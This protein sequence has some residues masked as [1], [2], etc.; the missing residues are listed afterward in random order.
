MGIRPATP[1][2]LVVIAATILLILVSVS[3][4]LLKSIYFLK[5]TIDASIDGTD[6]SGTV[7]LGAWGYCVGSTCSTPKLGYSLDVAEL[8]G[9]S[10]A[11]TGISTS[12]LKWI[13][14][15]MVLHPIA[16]AFGVVSVIFGLL[17]HIRGFAGTA[18]TTCFASFA[19]T[20]AS[21]AFIFDIVVFVIAKQRI[22]SS[23]VGGNAQLGP[24]I[25]MTLVALIL[26]TF[27]GCFFGCGACVI[28]KR[29]ADRVASEKNRPLPDEEY[30][31]KMRAEAFAAHERDQAEMS[32]GASLPTFF[33]REQI[34]LNSLAAVDYEDDGGY[35]PTPYPPPAHAYGN[36]APSIIS[37]VGEGYGRRNP[38]GPGMPVS[39]S[40]DTSYSA[41]PATAAGVAGGAASRLAP[42]ARLNRGYGSAVDDH[43]HNSATTE[44]FVGMHV[45]PANSTSPPVSIHQ[46]ETRG[47]PIY[48]GPPANGGASAAPMPVPQ[49][50][51]H[52]PRDP[53]QLSPT[54]A[55]G[56]AYPPYP[57]AVATP[58]PTSHSSAEK[59]A[60]VPQLHQP[61]LSSASPSST[62]LQPAPPPQQFYVQNPSAPS[63]YASSLQA[64]TYYT[65]DQPQPSAQDYRDPYDGTAGLAYNPPQ[66]AVDQYGAYGYDTAPR[67]Y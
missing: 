2:T 10:G 29:R 5:A 35:H 26:F 24:A 50:H 25:W 8:F 9:V 27:S 59:S 63:E 33:E 39:L 20:F 56:G 61:Y 38:A 43:R 37:G 12:V 31:S 19:A 40:P 47:Y 6:V 7:T 60:Y 30:G 58:M 32:K 44:P 51:L 64:P 36:D 46:H 62:H 65:H 22:Q 34:P 55:I 49:V 53:S 3:T 41:L 28:R 14:Y 16:A 15:L 66:N 21:L 1:G 4:P 54:A 23:D 18:L 42:E 48:D 17:A 11:L 13:T 67:R 57:P 52:G 45:P